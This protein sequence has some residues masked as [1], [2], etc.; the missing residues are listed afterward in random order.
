MGFFQK[1]QHAAW[2]TLISYKT[3]RIILIKDYKLGILHK[4]LLVGV[5]IYLLYTILTSHAYMIT[6]APAATV[7]SW[8]DENEFV[9]K[10]KETKNGSLDKPWY[11][12]NVQSHY[13]YS[14]GFTYLNNECDLEATVG[15]VFSEESTAV[16][17]VTYY[18]DS[19]LEKTGNRGTNVNNF[20]PYVEDIVFFF[21]HGFTTSLGIG[22]ANVET[23]VKSSDGSLTKRF[24][25]GSPIRLKISDMLDMAGIRLDD[26]HEK[27]GGQEPSGGFESPNW[28]LY[29]MTGIDITLGKYT[30]V[31]IVQEQGVSVTVMCA[32]A[33]MEYKNFRSD[34]I[35]DFT[36]KLDVTVTATEGVWV[37]RGRPIHPKWEDDMLIPYGR[38]PQVISVSYRPSGMLRNING[39]ISILNRPLH[40]VP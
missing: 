25:K 2:D 35:F 22:A 3:Q 40:D 7:N 38:Y 32:L 17:F 11:C 30:S 36:S 16:S 31:Y 15:E 12:D 19:T 26:R 14:D 27:S 1:Y 29:R 23:L 24:A 5:A 28:P 34:R 39:C 20:I 8:V 18:Q 4:S 6:E 37:S 9:H 13:V 10:L 33:E 21:S